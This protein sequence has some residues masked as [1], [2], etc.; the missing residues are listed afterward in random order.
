MN[1]MPAITIITFLPLLVGLTLLAWRPEAG[2]AKRFAVALAAVV[3]L[4]AGGL[5][6][7]FDPDA[8]GMQFEQR[9]AWIPAL[10]VDYCVGIDGISLLLVGLTALLVP[11]AILAGSVNGPRANL[12]YALILFLESGLLGTFTALNFFHWFLF[13]ELSL[14]PAFFLVKLWGGPDRGPAATQFFFYT[15]VGSVAMLL[16][17]LALF[18]ATGT[19]DFRALAELGQQGQLGD[20]LAAKIRLGGIEARE[21]ALLVFLGVF[22]GFAVKVP[23]IP[24]HT[25]LPGTY[26]TAPTP[27]TMLLTGAMSKMGVYGFLRILLP[28]FPEQVRAV[29]P[30]LLLLALATIVLSAWS[31]FAQTD[32]KRMFAYSSINHLGYCLLGIFLAARLSTR[33]ADMDIERAAVLNGVVLQM[34]NHGLTAASLFCLLGWLEQRSGGLRCMA[35][36]GGLRKVAPV[37]CGLM[38]IATFASLGLPGLNGFIG[39]FLVFKGAFA[40][41]PW[42]AALAVPGLLITAIFLLTFLQRVFY[43]PLEERW[44]S[45]PDLTVGER[46]LLVVPI[47]LMFL[48]GIVPQVA[49]HLVNPTVIR[50]VEGLTP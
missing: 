28:I 16:G 47:G 13:W 2:M 20:L 9:L 3:L 26:A 38:G 25:W 24:F 12:Y 22:L 41:S 30:I 10:G 19:F 6:W 29:M 5:W 4:G 43:G 48:I 34:F 15:M 40:L 8:A 44:S 50:L 36:F 31:A 1:G 39:E 42:S 35:D 49:L 17:F 46:W 32:L 21:L 14:I 33:T 7:G 11:F 23:A 27:V 18:L 45:F 37:F